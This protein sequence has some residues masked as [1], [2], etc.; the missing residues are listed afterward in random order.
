MALGGG[1]FVKQ[2][3][4]LPGS[5]INFVSAAQA[6][7]GVS[8]R[9]YAAM[10]LEMSWGPAEEVFTLTSETVQED[11]KKLFGYKYN[12]EKMKGIRDLFKNAM[13]LY[14][15]RI[16]GN[17]EK[18][19]C[20]YGKARYGGV[21]GNDLRLVIAGCQNG[22]EVKTYLDNEEVDSQIVE[23]M[24]QLLDNDYVVFN[25]E[26]TLE[27]T[28]GIA[29]TGGTDSAPKTEDYEKFLDKI[30]SYSFQAL[31]LP[32]TDDSVK[33]LFVDF[34]KEM[35][36]K[37]GIKFQTVCFRFAAD[38]EGVVSLENCVE[39][40][41]TE[42]ELAG[43]D[44]A[45][46]IYWTTGAISGCKVNASNTNKVYEGE[47]AIDVSYTQKQLEEAIQSGKFIF[48]R[49]GDGVRVLEDLNSLLTFTEEKGKDFSSNQTIRVLDQIGND[50]ASLFGNKYLGKIPNDE[51]GRVS[52]WN[53]VVTYYKELETMRA[54]ENFKADDIIITKGEGKKSI[55][56]SCPVTPVNA[57]SQL[58][59]TVIVQ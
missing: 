54:I 16:N 41:V 37:M 57:M 35:R 11:G 49:V 14:G 12:H 4:V 56:A 25:R 22:Y 6:N 51:A 33:E 5:Y 55:V 42:G 59:M 43:N 23:E 46:L 27:D 17:G 29:F 50:I 10:P 3:K 26:G 20:D 36:D 15:Y 30:G 48:H 28:A 7:T 40:T 44:A 13:V 39:G 58:Y 53:D 45:Q 1:N 8:E 52:F 19:S 34:T 2:N 38:Y 18:A 32:S 24:G 47:Y 21:R 9:G 31:G